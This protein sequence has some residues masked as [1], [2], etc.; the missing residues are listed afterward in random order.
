MDMKFRLQND[1]R[2]VALTEKEHFTWERGGHWLPGKHG[3]YNAV[4]VAKPRNP[5]LRKCINQIIRHVAQRYYGL[6]PLYPTGP[7]MMWLVHERD[8]SLIGP[9]LDLF[10]AREGEYILYRNRSILSKIPDYVNNNPGG[11]YPH[12]FHQRRIYQ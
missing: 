1:F 11:Y 3:I 10:H 12:L 8:P 9:S 2:L 4:I 5:F 7:G 6:N